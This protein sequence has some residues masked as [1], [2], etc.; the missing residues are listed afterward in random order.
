MPRQRDVESVGRANQ[1]MKPDEESRPPPQ[2]MAQREK[3]DNEQRVEW[4][5]VGRKRDKEI[6]P[7]HDDVPTC[8]RGAKLLKLAA[9]KPSPNH[10]R[11]F[12]A[13]DVKPHRFGQKK[14]DRQ[15]AADAR[16]RGYPNRIRLSRGSN[17]LH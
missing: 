2:P 14:I 3:C 12:M 15:P 16:E 7:G 1:E 10:M 17:E 9:E 4:E 11:Q 6:G 8:G 13:D 5:K